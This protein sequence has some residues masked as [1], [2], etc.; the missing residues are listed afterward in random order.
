METK[1]AKFVKNMPNG[2]FRGKAS[3]YRL[4]HPVS[5]YFYDDNCNFYDDNCKEIHKETSYVIVSAVIAMFSGPETYIF[6]TT[7]TGEILNWGELDGS[8]RGGLN[9]DTALL[10]AGYELV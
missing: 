2:E 7:E 1:T 9:H 3:L 10:N 4:S 8:Y 5:Y 6:P